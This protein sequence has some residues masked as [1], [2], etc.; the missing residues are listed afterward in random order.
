MTWESS[1]R[2]SHNLV[3]VILESPF[4]GE[5]EVNSA[6]ARRCALDCLHRSEAPFASH[7]IYGATGVLREADRDERTLGIAAGLAWLKVCELHVF[8]T[9]RGWSPGMIGSLHLSIEAQQKISFRSL[10]HHV[11][12]PPALLPLEMDQLLKSLSSP[13]RAVTFI[14]PYTPRSIP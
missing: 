6:Y 4:N 13:T 1:E 7:L 5:Q 8:Y 14:P 3:R 2:I 10:D 12:A 9:D 11:E